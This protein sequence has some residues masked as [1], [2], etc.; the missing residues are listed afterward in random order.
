MNKFLYDYFKD[1]PLIGQP[2]KLA[3]AANLVK[4]VISKGKRSSSAKD[5]KELTGDELEDALN[6]EANNIF[7]EHIRPEISS[8]PE[9]F[10]GQIKEKAIENIVAK[11]REDIEK[12]TEKKAEASKK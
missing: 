2:I 3:Y 5:L 10:L 8:I 6:K 7:D 12:K 1:F 9:P 11:L 4:D